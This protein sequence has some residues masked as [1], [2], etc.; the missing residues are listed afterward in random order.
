V[1]FRIWWLQTLTISLWWSS[2]SDVFILLEMIKKQQQPWT[3]VSHPF[4][5]H[6]FICAYD[7]LLSYNTILISDALTVL[8]FIFC[9]WYFEVFMFLSKS[10]AYDILFCIMKTTNCISSVQL[11]LLFEICL[12]K[13][14]LAFVLEHRK[15]LA[16]V[17]EYLKSLACVL[18]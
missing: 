5:F 11:N 6:F 16:C 15:S 12:F 3:L 10:L 4:F 2:D 17:L 8:Y 7:I 1:F 9:V 14:S 13:K 18:T